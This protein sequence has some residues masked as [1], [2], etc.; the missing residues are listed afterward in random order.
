[1][2]VVEGDGCGNDCRVHRRGGI[3][4]EGGNIVVISGYTIGEF[5]LIIGL[6][7]SL[8]TLMAVILVMNE[9]LRQEFGNK[10]AMWKKVLFVLFS[11]VAVTVLYSFDIR[12]G[13]VM[14]INGVFSAFIVSLAVD[15][16]SVWN[17][18]AKKVDDGLEVQSTQQR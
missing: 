2:S 15:V 12:I 16:L 9:I 4:V 8:V 5:F 7:Y 17:P 1:V 10:S 18:F 6:T 11:Y 13:S 14:F 3:V